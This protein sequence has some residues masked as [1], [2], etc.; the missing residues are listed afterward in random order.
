[1]I[2]PVT[3]PGRRL[4]AGACWGLLVLA[5]FALGGRPAFAGQG[6]EPNRAGLVIQFEGGRI[7]KRCVEFEAAEITGADL[8]A[9]SDLDTVVDA[10]S[11]LGIT[12]CRIEGQ[13]CSYPAEPCFCR[14]SGS[15]ACAYWNYFYRDP[16][17]GD[18][19]YAPLG[20][21]LHK[22]RAGSV[23]AWVWGNGQTP[24]AADLTFEAVCGVSTVATAATVRPATAAPAASTAL[25]AATPWPGPTAMTAQ[26]T[27]APVPDGRGGASYWLFGVMALGLGLAGAFIWLRGR[28]G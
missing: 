23:D 12:V 7:E 24:P 2:Q 26:A 10:S 8:L 25:P 16:A 14:C 15:G 9:R 28:R 17:A 19:T 22:V 5:L 18:W 11:G 3:P 13:G 27:S 6:S 4:L 1:M 21:L 20:A